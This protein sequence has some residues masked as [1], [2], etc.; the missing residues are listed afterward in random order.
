MKKLLGIVILSLLVYINPLNTNNSNAD[1]YN[2]GFFFADPYV[3]G[4]IYDLLDAS[5][6]KKCAQ[7]SIKFYFNERKH[8]GSY[9]QAYDKCYS[10]LRRLGVQKYRNFNNEDY[11]ISCSD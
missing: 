2:R 1:H 9:D 8:R 10:Y 7:R 11:Q 6:G 5:F 3:I 4:C